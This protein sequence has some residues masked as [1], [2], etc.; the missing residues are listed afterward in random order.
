MQV[1][2][3]AAYLI[4]ALKAGQIL[5]TGAEAKFSAA[6]ESIFGNSVVISLS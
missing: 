1:A 5:F 6:S 2:S 4:W 3:K